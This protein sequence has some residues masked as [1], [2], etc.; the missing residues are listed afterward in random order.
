MLGD[1]FGKR[2]VQCAA[3]AMGGVQQVGPLVGLT[4]RVLARHHR[5][6][7]AALQQKLQRTHLGRA[8]RAS[9]EGVN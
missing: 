3:R 1:L 6:R 9:K 8:F 5:H 7:C 2:E 4:R